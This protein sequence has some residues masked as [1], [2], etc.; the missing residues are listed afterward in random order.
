M[1]GP[2]TFHARMLRE[3][4]WSAIPQWREVLQEARAQGQE[5]RAQYAQWM[6][7]EVLIDSHAG[8]EG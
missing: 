2:E 8:G 4:R 5:H 6:L 1:T 3:W 7:T